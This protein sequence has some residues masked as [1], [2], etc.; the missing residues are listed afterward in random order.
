M[1]D[2]LKMARCMKD[3][4]DSI[5]ENIFEQVY[6]CGLISSGVTCS[7]YVTVCNTITI[8]SIRYTKYTA[9]TCLWIITICSVS[10]LFSVRSIF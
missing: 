5:E 1:D 6:V 4:L 2:L 3:T 7:I 9:S 10:A 8:T